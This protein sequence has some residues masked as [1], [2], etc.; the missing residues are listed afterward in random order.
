MATDDVKEWLA[1]REREGLRI[2]PETAEVMWRYVNIGDPYDLDPGPPEE[3]C[4]GRGYFARRP[5]SD[6]WVEFGDLPKETADRLEELHGRKLHFPA[7]LQEMA[8][9]LGLEEIFRKAHV[10]RGP[11]SEIRVEFGDP[12]DRLGLEE[13]F[14]KARSGSSD[15]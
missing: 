14:R 9:R 15:S 1:A 7:G 11:G 3:E 4:I 2:D 13:I 6:I 12:A 5:G 10:V 8:A